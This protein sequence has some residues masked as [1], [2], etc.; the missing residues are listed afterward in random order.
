MNIRKKFLKI[1]F[2]AISVISFSLSP[3]FI[4][5][6]DKTHTYSGVTF[7]D[8]GSVLKI[9]G[10]G[11]GS[12]VAQA[13]AS[14]LAVWHT[15]IAFLS[16]MGMLTCVLMFIVNFLKLSASNIS[17]TPHARSQAIRNLL[18]LG[19]T[20]SLLGANTLLMSLFYGIIF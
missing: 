10:Q 9:T 14:F 16:A 5:A 6:D 13:I 17:A 7:Q 8:T 20:T 11:N 19:V 12:P 2:F 15:F 4:F 1:Q 18:I 3:L